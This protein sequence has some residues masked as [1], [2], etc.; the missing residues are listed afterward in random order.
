MTT[1]PP[2]PTITLHTDAA[3]CPRADV[4]I[5]PMPGDAVTVTIWRNYLGIR[6]P[7]RD[8]VNTA[9]AGDFL[10]TD[11]ELPPV[12]SADGG[13]SY[14][15]Q[16][17][18]VSGTPSDLSAA[19]TAQVLDFAGGTWAQDPLDPS[20]STLWPGSSPGDLILKAPT[21]GT[22]TFSANQTLS[23]VIGSPLP[24]G[25]TGIRRAA[26]NI[27]IVMATTTPAMISA[28]MNLLTQAGGCLAVRQNLA[29]LHPPLMYLQIGD[30]TPVEDYSPGGRVVWSMV[31]TRV[32]PSA[33]NVVVPVRTYTDLAGEAPTYAALALLYA[34]YLDAQRGL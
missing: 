6:E 27:P 31:G 7:V 34:T 24:I 22:G 33:L 11:Y 17:F 19:S 28:L 8:A 20:T 12:T 14:T 3:P 16:T 5:T 15:A 26:A 13:V 25:M 10:V 23:P 21:F 18:D 4:L 2:A 1:T 9:V 30:I 29:Q 32:Q